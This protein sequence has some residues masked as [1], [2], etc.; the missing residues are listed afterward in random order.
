MDIFTTITPGIYWLL[1]ISWAFIFIFYLNK[2][3]RTKNMDQLIRLLLII[4]AIDAFRTLFESSFFGLW[5]TS[6]AG[7][8]PIYINDFLTQPQ[9]VFVPKLINLV[10]SMLILFFLI[11]KWIPAEISRNLKMKQVIILKTEELEL[12]NKELIENKQILN[13]AQSMANIGHWELNL[14]TQKIVYSD[15][16]NRIL[17][18]NKQEFN[19]DYNS[20]LELIH[21]DDQN[22]VKDKFKEA[23]KHSK[24]IGVV[25]RIVLANGN[26]RTV[27]IKIKIRYNAINKTNCLVGMLWDITKQKRNEQEFQDYKEMLENNIQKRTTELENKNI[28]LQNINNQLEKYNQLF[29]DREFRI[30]EL[31]EKIKQLEND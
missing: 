5:Y 11:K 27:E 24:S 22:L 9:I 30:N 2:L 12:L 16:V 7:L 13:E 29:V 21:I 18:F 31:K 8:I 10:V 23:T 25:S 4:L 20:F 15:E 26:I 1:V 3:I 14:E 6:L 17:G 19:V 28:E